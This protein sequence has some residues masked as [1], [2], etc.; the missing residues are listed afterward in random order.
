MAHSGSEGI[1]ML[2]I[3]LPD[4]IISW[5]DFLVSEGIYSS[6]SE[7]LRDFLRDFVMEYPGDKSGK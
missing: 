1:A 7:A 6:R 4:E 2:N 3:R 5:L